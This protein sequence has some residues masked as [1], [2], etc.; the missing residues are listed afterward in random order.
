MAVSH[1]QTRQ[2]EIEKLDR[3]IAE[4]DIG[5]QH[6]A[7]NLVQV[8]LAVPSVTI[9]TTTMIHHHTAGPLHISLAVLSCQHTVNALPTYATVIVLVA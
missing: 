4:K 2:R 7:N 3:D 6:M 5:L 8:R 9:C 1:Q